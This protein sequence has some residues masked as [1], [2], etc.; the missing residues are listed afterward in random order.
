MKSILFVVVFVLGI[1]LNGQSKACELDAQL[2]TF[3]TAVAEV[4]K[5]NPE[6]HK[7]AQ[8][9]KYET[10]TE[11]SRFRDIVPSLPDLVTTVIAFHGNGDD[12]TLVNIVGFSDGCAIGGIQ[13]MW[14]RFKMLDV[15]VTGKTPA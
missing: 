14:D 15:Y 3:E 7:G 8:F 5:S 4:L 2:A 9:F 12:D 6:T 1:V 13:M 11:I 10:E